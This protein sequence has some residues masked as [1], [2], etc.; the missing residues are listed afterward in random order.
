VDINLDLEPP[1]IF[2]VWFLGLGK[3]WCQFLAAGQQQ[4]EGYRLGKDHKRSCPKSYEFLIYSLR[5]GGKMG[6]DEGFHRL[7][8]GLREQ[9]FGRGK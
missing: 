7:A 8:P 6:A 1:V 2:G 9:S 5:S 3:R 4:G